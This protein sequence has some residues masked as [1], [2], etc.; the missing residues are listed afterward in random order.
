MVLPA[1]GFQEDL[2]R[3]VESVP[4]LGGTVQL[5]K[6]AWLS[7]N[8]PMQCLNGIFDA[9]SGPCSYWHHHPFL[10]SVLIHPHEFPS[11]L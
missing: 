1:L 6:A 2:E 7:W 11:F 8:R 3:H 4:V 9:I 10:I 5:G